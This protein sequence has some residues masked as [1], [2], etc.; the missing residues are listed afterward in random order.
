MRP[1]PCTCLL[2]GAVLLTACSGPPPVP[3]TEPPTPPASATSAAAPQ[4]TQARTFTR[5]GVVYPG[6]VMDLTV[7]AVERHSS[8]TTLKMELSSDSGDFQGPHFGH[9]TLPDHFAEF[10]LLDP[11]GKKLYWTLREN[12]GDGKA[13]GTRHVTSGGDSETWREG[14]R[15]PVE[16]YFPPLPPEVEKVTVIGADGLAE[17]TGIPVTA[18]TA[19][20]VAKPRDDGDAA[21]GQEFQWP[22]TPPAGEIWSQVEDLQEFVETEQR[23]TTQAGADETVALR[24]DVLFAFDKATLSAKATAVLDEVARETGERA[25]PPLLIEG[26]TDS[27]GSAPYN[28][29]L[30]ERRARAVRD[31]L[32]TRLGDAY[33]YRATGKGES[34]PTAANQRPDGSDNPDGRARNRRVEISYKIKQEA[35]TTPSDSTPA[36]FR[37]DLGPVIGS[38]TRGELKVDVHPF[39]RDGAY[40]VGS[41]EVRNL[42]QDVAAVPQPQ[43]FSGVFKHEW[44]THS[45][46][47]MFTVVDE[48]RRARHYPVRSSESFFVENAVTAIG[49]GG[50]QRVF[51]YFPAPPDDVKSVTF[52][53]KDQVQNFGKVTD[54]PVLAAP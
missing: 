43:P 50:T 54:V 38:I 2:V 21:P 3:D 48:S 45:A 7:E 35:P 4:T 12:D 26:H 46:Y 29:T 6:T 28:Q 52:E 24:T 19:A 20:P 40:L 31:H 18:A 8:L 39:Y 25:E 11:V 34:E 17:L 44:V 14:T 33:D 37:D 53:V 5:E 47:G 42:N 1:L 9:G 10:W 13:F 16:V 51:V 23:S 27:K 36:E 49:P 41:F 22:V 32:A 15:Y 30:S